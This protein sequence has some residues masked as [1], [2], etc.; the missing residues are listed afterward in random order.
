[1]TRKRQSGSA[2]AGRIR[3]AVRHAF[4]VRVYDA[5]TGKLLFNI[6]TETAETDSVTFDRSGT[7]LLLFRRETLEVFSATDGKKFKVYDFQ[8]R[9]HD[10]DR[11]AFTADGKVRGLGNPWPEVDVWDLETGNP[12]GE[13][14]GL[15]TEVWYL[16]FSADGKHLISETL[17]A[18]VTWDVA[19][20]VSLD[21]RPRETEDEGTRPDAWRSPDG[22]RLIEREWDGNTSTFVGRDKTSR[23]EALKEFYRIDLAKQSIPWGFSFVVFS[24]DGK[25]FVLHNTGKE[26][27]LHGEPVSGDFSIYDTATGKPTLTLKLEKVGGIGA[28]F[29]PDGRRLVLVTDHPGA[30]AKGLDLMVFDTK[31]GKLIQR[32]NVP[33]G[34][35]PQLWVLADNRTVLLLSMDE[36]SQLWTWDITAGR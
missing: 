10:P 2:S 5:T 18:T 27:S 13:C 20:R 26:W 14:R 7:R 34:F 15:G 24:P 31:T 23:D 8:I 4:A 30:W 9:Q 21:Q 17:G 35:S 33:S 3:F 22:K 19:K 32:A 29:S 16:R 6:P 12:L 11:V 36:E 1:M 25:T 28:S